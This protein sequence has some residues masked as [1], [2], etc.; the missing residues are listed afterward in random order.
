MTNRWTAFESLLPPEGEVVMT[1]IED[2]GNTRNE[3]RLIRN[4]NLMFTEDM[5]MYVYYQPTHWKYP[6]KWDV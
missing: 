4:G 1:K 2:T 3:A 6:S 5:R